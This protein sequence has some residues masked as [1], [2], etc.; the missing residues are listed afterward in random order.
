MIYLLVAVVAVG[1]FVVGYTFGKTR[2]SDFSKIQKA[3]YSAMTRQLSTA[4]LELD[5]SLRANAQYR[6]ALNDIAAGRGGLAEIT[7]AA[8]LNVVNNSKEF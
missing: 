7:A 6:S 3:E 4:N 1:I 8:A 5:Q 2:G